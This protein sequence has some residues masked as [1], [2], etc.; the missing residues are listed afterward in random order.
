MIA[1][2]VILV[3]P[4]NS[5]SWDVFGYYLYLPFTFHYHDL[6]LHH[7]GT[8]QEIINTYHNTDTFYQA[9]KCDNGNWVMKYPMGLAVLYAPFYFIGQA[10]AG[11]TGARTDGFSAPY[12]LSILYGCLFY[13]LVGL[14]Y[15]RKVL[16]HF[17]EDKIAALTLLAVVFGT[18]YFFHVSLHGQG[19]M[20]HNMLF[21]L[22]SIITWYTIR[23][24]Q[25]Q[26]AKHMVIIGLCIGLAALVRPT[27]IISSLIPLLFGINSLA[28]LRQK[29]ALLLRHKG[30]I[31]LAVLITA[32][33]GSCQLFYWKAATGKYFYNSYSA[34]NPGEGFEFL[35]PFIAEVLFS[36]RKGWF[37]YT[38]VMLFAVAGLFVIPKFRKEAGWM[39]L[40]YFLINLYIV[41]SWSCWWYAGSFSSRALIPSYAIM[42]L[43][44]G[45]VFSKL[46]LTRARLLF[47]PAVSLLVLLNLFQSW[48]LFKGILHPTDMTRAYYLSVFGQTT[49]PTDGQKKLLLVNRFTTLSEDFTE[50]ARQEHQLCYARFDTYN[51][52]NAAPVDGNSHYFEAVDFTPAIKERYSVVTK[53]YYAWIKASCLFYTSLN[54][55]S[56]NA[57]LCVSMSHKGATFKFRGQPVSGKGFKKNTWNKLEFYYMTPELRTTKDSVAVF[58]WN[59]SGHNMLIDSLGFEAL[60]PKQDKSVF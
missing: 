4:A 47:I 41:A 11:I 18:N 57:I 43:P 59:M 50:E 7:D 33:I 49:P 52:R 5:L 31:L 19:T 15:F 26:K 38:P 54:P 9:M 2:C 8:V 30:Q 32:A 44:L 13:T 29:A 51:D 17:F 12:Q 37:I 34:G 10:W 22:Y 58:F 45:A 55:D 23:W 14:H 40:V 48:Q 1:A 3:P 35:H 42:A 36:F 53:K 21:S 6:M 28:A 16:A 27:E 20:S 24:H 56:C 46:A 25:Q 39:P 60:E